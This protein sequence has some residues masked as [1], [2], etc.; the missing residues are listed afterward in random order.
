MGVGDD[1]VVHPLTGERV[2]FLRTGADTGGEVLEMEDLWVRADHETPAHVHPCME[3]RWE[4]LEG[5][6]G[7]RVGDRELTA[8][9]KDTVVA[10]AGVPHSARNLGGGRVRLRIEMRPALRWEEVVRR[11]FADADPDLPALL[12]EFPDELAA[13]PADLDRPGQA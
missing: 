1:A 6:V 4:V 5:R 13:A 2:T 12:R 11:L 7:F 3:E 8:V 9:P 10:P